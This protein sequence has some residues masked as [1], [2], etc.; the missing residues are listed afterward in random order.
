CGQ[1][2][3]GRYNLCLAYGCIGV[4]HDGGYGNFVK[5]PNADATLVALPD[6]IDAFTAAALGCRFMTSYHAVVNQGAVRPGE[7]IAV[8]GVGGVGLSAIQIAAALGARVIAIGRSLDKLAKARDEGAEV[9][10]TAGSNAAAEIVDVTQGGAAVT[11]D[12]L[13]ASETTL[14]ALQSLA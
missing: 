2:R 7:W 6:N 12:A 11:I 5:V 10:I 8:C 9:T 3:A 14:P 1:C 4:H 13:G